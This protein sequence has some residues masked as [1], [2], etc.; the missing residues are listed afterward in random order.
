MKSLKQIEVRYSETDQMGVVYHA[1]YLVWM[2][3][4][5]TN[6]LKDI[7]FDMIDFEEMGYLF[8]VYSMDIKFLNAARYGE[9]IR[10]E[11]CV[12]EVNKIRTVYSQTV[13]NDRNEI[14]VKALVTIVCVRKEDFK[15]V[16]VDKE[17]EDLYEGLYLNKNS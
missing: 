17:L 3:M 4:G 2:E 12:S 1:N 15:A 8:P 9:K 5:R 7:G 14:K 11:T 13:L 16:R 6:F 10:V